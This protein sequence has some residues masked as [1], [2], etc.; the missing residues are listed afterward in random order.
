MRT[1]PIPTWVKAAI[2]EWKEA[3][4]ITEGAIFRSLSKVGRVWGKGITAKALWQFVRHA[5]GSAGIAKT[6][7]A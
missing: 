5:A 4:G 6:C 7:S 1:V 2:E 3:S